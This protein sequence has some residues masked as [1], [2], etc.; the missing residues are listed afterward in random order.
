MKFTTTHAV[1]VLAMLCLFSIARVQAQDENAQAPPPTPRN[2]ADEL[3][4]IYL[5]SFDHK[6]YL[7]ILYRLMGNNQDTW[8][9]LF[10]KD[11]DHHKGQRDR[12]KQLIFKDHRDFKYAEANLSKPEYSPITQ[13]IRLP[14]NAKPSDFPMILVMK[15]REGHV[16]HI[17]GASSGSILLHQELK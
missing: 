11:G 17:N 5:H 12:I 3:D 16:I 14:Q 4:D 10:Y 6:D 2:E 9:V 15:N 13:A 1:M 7:D 8:I